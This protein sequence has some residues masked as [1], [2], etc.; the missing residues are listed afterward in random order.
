MSASPE[1]KDHPINENNIVEPSEENLDLQ[2]SEAIVEDSFSKLQQELESIQDRYL[3]LGAEFENFK[4]RSERDRL[5]SI[6]FA[7]ENLLID[8]LPVI[9]HL[10][11]AISAAKENPAADDVVIGI[12][13]V[14]KQFSDILS[15]SGLRQ[16]DSLGTPFNPNLH[17]ALSEMDSEE[18]DSGIIVQEYQ[19]GYM[20]NERLVRP[21]RVVVSKKK[22][23]E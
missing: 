14:L 13:M 16:F 2:E 10:E 1:N 15:K 22:V 12:K 11:H 20:L 9:D 6:R 5:S 23:A 21:A 8:L 18:H 17:E 7:N 3:R 19:K 4:K